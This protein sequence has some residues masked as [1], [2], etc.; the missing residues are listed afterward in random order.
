MGLCCFYNLSPIFR[1]SKHTG[2]YH[3]S[4]TPDPI[5][6]GHPRP[7]P[8]G[9]WPRGWIS[10]ALM[11]P[12]LAPVGTHCGRQA[13]HILRAPSGSQHWTAAFLKW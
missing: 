7:S 13:I 9:I 3:E 1:A 10:E 5:S 6:F 4:V 11:A 2:Y 12:N 8:W